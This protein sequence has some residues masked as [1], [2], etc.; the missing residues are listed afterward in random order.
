[1]L[2]E[3]FLSLANGSYDEW[4]GEVGTIFSLGGGTSMRLAG[5]QPFAGAGSRPVVLARGSA[6]LVV[7]DLLD[8][9][10]MA[11]DLIYTAHHPLYGPLQIFLSASSDPRTPGRMTAVFN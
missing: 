11:G 10:T 4:L 9:Q 6:F 2:R 7:F 3:I 5:V 8:G 1:M